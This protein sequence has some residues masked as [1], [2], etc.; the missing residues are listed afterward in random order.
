MAYSHKEKELMFDKMIDYISNGM[1]LRTALKQ[2]DV[3]SKTIW[4]ELIKDEEKNTRYAR[5]CAERADAIFEEIIEIA[6]NSGN[7]KIDLGDGIEGVN[8]EA[9]Q[10]DRLRVDARKWAVSKMNPKKYGDKLGL[11]HSG[12]IKTKQSDL[13]NLSEETLKRVEKE[14]S[15]NADNS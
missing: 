11:E 15:K 1:S 13:S 3:F 12:E 14:L 7:D 6:D 2:D 8:H 10:R 5:A 9:I 4:D